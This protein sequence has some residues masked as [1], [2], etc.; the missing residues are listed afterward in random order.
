MEKT[1]KITNTKGLQMIKD[2]LAANGN[3]DAELAAWVDAKIEQDAHVK[4]YRKAHPAVRKT[5]PEVEARREAVLAVLT[6]EP[7]GSKD[8]AAKANI[9]VA[10]AIGAL[11]ALVKAGKAVSADGEKKT[12][13]YS[14]A[15]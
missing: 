12:K 8:I 4:E 10:K 15:K 3:T 9:T 7:T 6:D 13:V 2:F 14:L 1:E 11:T 5:N